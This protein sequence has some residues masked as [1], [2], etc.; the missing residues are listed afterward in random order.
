MALVPT[1]HLLTAWCTHCNSNEQ[2][3]TYRIT[4]NKRPPQN[5][6]F[7]PSSAM[8]RRLSDSAKEKREKRANRKIEEGRNL[9]AGIK[10]PMI[11][12]L[13]RIGWDAVK[14]N[15]ETGIP[16]MTV[17]DSI[18]HYEEKGT[19]DATIKPNAIAWARKYGSKS[20]AEKF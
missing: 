11:E 3:Y 18:K 15:K 16:L 4:S 20:A 14:I 9:P 10:H 17:R 6:Y 2:K 12:G 19:C 5:P 8:P 13:Y 7:V 1:V